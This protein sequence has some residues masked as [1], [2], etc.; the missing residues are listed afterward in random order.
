M[1]EFLGFL[2]IFLL[3]TIPALII[4]AYS[5]INIFVSMLGVSVAAYILFHISNR[6]N[7]V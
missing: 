3:I 6:D 4:S 2:V 7:I 5:G 1:N